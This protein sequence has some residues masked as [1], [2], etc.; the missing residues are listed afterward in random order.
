MQQYGFTPGKSTDLQ[1]TN[2]QLA[3]EILRKQNQD[4]VV[5]FIDLKKAFDS[6][7][8]VDIFNLLMGCNISKDV[9]EILWKIYGKDSTI[10][11]IN[12][13]EQ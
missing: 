9:I 2:L 11:L 8:H 1:I 13:E 4:F 10:Y 3:L 5:I 7:R 6:A 12:Q